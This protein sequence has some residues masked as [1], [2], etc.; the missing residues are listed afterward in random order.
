MGGIFERVDPSFLA[1][2]FMAAMLGAWALGWRRGRHAPLELGEDP[3]VRFTD[4]A[5]AL[6]GLLLAFTFSMSLGKHDQRRAMVVA[7]SNAIGDFYTCA[8]LLPSPARSR[9]QGLIHEYAQRKLEVAIHLTSEA[10]LQESSR[11]FQDSHSRMTA[12]VAEALAEETPV[13]IPLTQT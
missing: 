8:S 9:L 10:D 13:A 5:F 1:L 12:A 3:G 11:W 4:A 2:A 7:E 6:L